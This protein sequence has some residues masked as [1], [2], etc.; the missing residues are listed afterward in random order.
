GFEPLEKF[1]DAF[2]WADFGLD[3]DLVTRQGGEDTAKLH[4]RSAIPA[5]SLD[6]VDAQFERPMDGSFEVG[7]V[8][9]R[10]FREVNI[11]PLE[12]VTHAAAGKHGHHQSSTAK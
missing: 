8:L 9:T 11:L 3:D 4:F 7:L 2:L 10:D 6:V 12:L 1:S 5:C